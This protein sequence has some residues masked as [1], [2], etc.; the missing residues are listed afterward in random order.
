MIAVI[1]SAYWYNYQKWI[2]IEYIE[3]KEVI[4]QKNLKD[5]CNRIKNLW[6]IGNEI[7]IYLDSRKIPVFCLYSSKHRFTNT[8]I[9]STI[10]IG[11]KNCE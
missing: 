7:V 5:S 2:S 3:Q 11:I 6:T 1:T 9:S 8:V 10:I 4:M